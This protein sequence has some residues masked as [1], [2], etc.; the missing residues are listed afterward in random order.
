MARMRL[1]EH[2]IIDSLPRQASPDRRYPYGMG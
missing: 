1:H 2:V